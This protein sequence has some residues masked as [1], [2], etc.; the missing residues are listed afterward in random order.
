MKLEIEVPD[1][2]EILKEG[3]IVPI[4]R[5]N[6]KWSSACL[7]G[8][9]KEKGVY[10]I[11]HAGKIMYVGKTDGPTMNFGTRLRRELQ[12]TA[13]QN[14]HIY[15]RLSA[16]PVPPDII[17]HCFPLSVIKQMVKATDRELLSFQLIGM[18][19]TAMI[20]HLE[21]EFQ[22]HQVNAMAVQVDKVITKLKLTGSETSAER[23][24]AIRSWVKE[25]MK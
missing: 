9:Q 6:E 3:C 4:A 23:R 19:E 7:G 15:P 5:K 14:K 21:P 17:V 1:A 2:G 13:S 24:P 25:M 12:E 10:V 20:Y 18:F 22:Q 11:H 8:M 16:L